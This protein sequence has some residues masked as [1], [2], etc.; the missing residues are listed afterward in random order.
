MRAEEW[1]GLL[2]EETR[3]TV[4]VYTT[5]S[6]LVLLGFVGIVVD[7]GYLSFRGREAQT[8]ADAAALGAMQMLY[9]G[10]SET[11]AT[12]VANEAAIYNRYSAANLTMGYLDINGNATLDPSQVVTATS[13]ISAT[14]ATLFLPIIGINSVQ[15]R[16][17][18][19][20][21]FGSGASPNA[22]ILL[23]PSMNSA[24]SITSSGS[25]NITGGGL[26][27]DS[28]SSTGSSLSSSG[29]VNSSTINGLVGGYHDSSS[30]GWHPTPTHITSVP[31]PLSKVPT[32]T[33]SGTANS[34]SVGNVNRSIGPGVYNNITLSSSGSLT[35]SAGT[36]IITGSF[37]LSSSGGVTGTNVTL[38]FTCGT[39]TPAA[40]QP[41]QSGGQLHLSS[42]GGMTL[43]PP[44]SGTYKG[45]VV[46]YDRNNT[47]PI[48]LS[49]SGG[50]NLTGTMYAKSAQL[51]LTS[52]GGVSQLNSL[53]V[54]DSLVLSSSANVSV[55]Y[56]ASQNYPIPSP[57][58]LSP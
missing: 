13:I 38:Y 17:T 20:A 22:V 30:G 24:L 54:I 6:L 21:V 33:L 12:S 29:G 32:P 27:V 9:G 28:S 50:Q 23:D 10:S 4:F 45:L 16:R 31:D 8:A 14:E 55:A 57:P 34:I 40:C 37:S 36:Y 58:V 56:A 43:T 53:L 44:T 51:K 25:L 2:R 15:V 48:T 26:A 39:S 49:S 35:M 41:G 47:S 18:S 42:S 52:S 46:F 5:F 11:T 19:R 3:G 1:W 7:Y